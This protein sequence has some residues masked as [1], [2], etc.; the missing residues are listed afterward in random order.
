M[1]G[2]VEMGWVGHL[3]WL[4]CREC[5]SRSMSNGGVVGNI[6]VGGWGM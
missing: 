1:L 5:W 4:R 2:N 6:D 3:K